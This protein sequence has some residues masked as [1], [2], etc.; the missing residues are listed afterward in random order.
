MGCCRAK[1]PFHQWRRQTCAKIAG[2]GIAAARSASREAGAELAAELKAGDW[3]FFE[4]R[5]CSGDRA[6]EVW[7]GKAVAIEDWGGKPSK[8][9][10]IAKGKRKTINGNRYDHG[11]YMI[12]IQWHEQVAADSDQL[13]FEV[14]APDISIQNSSTLR[15]A[16]FQPE[17]IQH[18]ALAGGSS[19]HTTWRVSADDI[20]TAVARCC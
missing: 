8:K 7:L 5:L 13:E 1:D 11:E 19:A 20:Q 12:A 16:G 14:G 18:P 3:C 6:L 10:N 2:T 4:H 9:A 17:T 15:L